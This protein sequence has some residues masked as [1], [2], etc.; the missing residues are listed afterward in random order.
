MKPL[1][2]TRWN[3]ETSELRS[4]VLYENKWKQAGGPTRDTGEEAH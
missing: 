2:M 4:E 1:P 3:E